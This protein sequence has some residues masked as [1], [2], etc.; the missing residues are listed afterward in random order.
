MFL[1][2]KDGF[3]V[4]RSHDEESLLGLDKNLYEITEWDGPLPEHDPTE[5]QLPDP[6]NE[7]QKTA[8]NRQ[9]YR[10]R[11]LRAYPSL[12][13]QLDMLYWDKVNETTEWVDEITRIKELY[14]KPG[15]VF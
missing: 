7:A 3:V 15:E 11:R 13:K 5:G 4:E 14:P 1:A 8:N 12:R 10:R 2:I 9:R 6:R